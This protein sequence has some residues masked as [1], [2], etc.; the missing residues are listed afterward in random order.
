[1]NV[2]I[3]FQTMTDNKSRSVNKEFEVSIKKHVDY[4]YTVLLQFVHQNHEKEYREYTRTNHS[5]PL[6]TAIY[7]LL[8]VLIIMSRIYTSMFNFYSGYSLNLF[9]PN[10]L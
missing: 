1:M 6:V 7:S 10:Y 4:E 8:V 5:H 2:D 9:F 3:E